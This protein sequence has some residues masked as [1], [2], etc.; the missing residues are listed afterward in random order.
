MLNAREIVWKPAYEVG[1]AVIDAQHRELLGIANSLIVATAEPI[2]AYLKLH[3]QVRSHFAHEEALMRRTGY[4]GQLHHESEHARLVDLLTS[5]RGNFSGGAWGFE[6]V[7]SFFQSWL[8]DHILS[9]DAPMI[10][11]VR[12]ASAEGD[13]ARRAA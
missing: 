12:S 5:V 2:E 9:Y 10:R 4:P 1:D 13:A 8:I 7:R 3:E 6:S 11:Y